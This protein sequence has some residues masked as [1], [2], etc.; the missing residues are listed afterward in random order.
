MQLIVLETVYCTGLNGEGESVESKFARQLNTDEQIWLRK[1]SVGSEWEPLETGW[2]ERASMMV[3]KNEEPAG[4]GMLELGLAAAGHVQPISSLP[5][6]T[7]L[8][9]PPSTLAS[10]RLRG[11]N[12]RYSLWLFPDNNA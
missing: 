9:L 6:S 7:S 11:H 1:A 3:L 10:L 8:R 5:P 4:G 2:I 12:T